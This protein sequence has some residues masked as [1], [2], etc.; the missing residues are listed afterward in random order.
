MYFICSLK[1]FNNILAIV[2]LCIKKNESIYEFDLPLRKV[3]LLLEQDHPFHL[4]L[5]ISLQRCLK[6]DKQLVAR[7]HD[8]V[9]KSKVAL[10]R[11]SNYG[12]FCG[13][14]ICIECLGQNSNRNLQNLYL[15]FYCAFQHKL[16]QPP[17]GRTHFSPR[18]L[19]YIQHPLL[20]KNEII[21]M[22]NYTYNGFENYVIFLI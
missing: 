4:A 19:T 15:Q 20:N 3:L 6:D 22:F 18:G 1:D 21:L 10:C 11:Y 17:K 12:V 2:N 7:Y 14:C 5:G 16:F 8:A 13:I 9:Q